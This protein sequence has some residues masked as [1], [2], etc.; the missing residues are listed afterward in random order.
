MCGYGTLREARHRLNLSQRQAN[1][2]FS[3]AEATSL[4]D[5]LELE[6]QQGE[7]DTAAQDRAP[8]TQRRTPDSAAV[9]ADH[10]RSDALDELLAAASSQALADELARRGWAC[11]SPD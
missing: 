7:A 2:K 4:I 3:I 10:R 9:R 11:I 5:Q 6:T 8:G 1:G